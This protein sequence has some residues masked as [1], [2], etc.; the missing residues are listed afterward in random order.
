MV[1]IGVSNIPTLCIDGVITF[2]S[3]IPPVNEIIK[4]IQARLD[5]K[6]K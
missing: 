5:K 3:N 2:V 4:A 6:N 1:G